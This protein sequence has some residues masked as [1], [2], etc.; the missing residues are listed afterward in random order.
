MSA[1]RIKI[2]ELY[3]S[4]QGEGMHMGLHCFFVRTAGCD[5]RCV[6][7]DTPAALEAGSG[8]WMEIDDIA[9]KIPDHVELVQI[10]GGEPLLQEERVLA[11]IERLERPPLPRKILLETGGHKSLARI[12]ESVHIVMDVKLPGSGEAGHDFAANVAYLKPTDEVKF[13]IADRADFDA[14]LDFIR[15]HELDKRC[16]ILYS[17]VWDSLE[18]RDLAAYILE[19]G[20][21]GRLQTQLHKWI[22]GAATT[23]V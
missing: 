2:A 22:W 5:L 17:P 16:R 8:D 15:E 7:C 18:L 3:A 6:W 20:A 23:G 9:A 19:A 13:V 14:A 11:L 4:L 1:T 12:P 10:T 21:P